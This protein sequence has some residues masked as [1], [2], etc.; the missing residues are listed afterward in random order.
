MSPTT[1]S[2]GGDSSCPSRPA[3]AG[4]QGG[5]RGRGLEQAGLRRRLG[6]GR[7]RGA[8]RVG[9]AAA[10]PLPRAPRGARKEAASTSCSVSGPSSTARA[11]RHHSGTSARDSVTLGLAVTRSLRWEPARRGRRR[12][13]GVSLGSAAPLH[14]PPRSRCL[15]FPSASSPRGPGTQPVAPGLTP[16]GVGVGKR[17]GHVRGHDL[18][19]VAVKHVQVLRALRAGDCG[20]GDG[21]RGSGGGRQ[22]PGGHEVQR[23]RRAAA[24]AGAA[25]TRD[26]AGARAERARGDR[27][28]GNGAALGGEGMGP[29]ARQGGRRARQAAVAPSACAPGPPPAAAQGAPP[30]ACPRPRCRR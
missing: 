16:P 5:D 22:P 27:G 10:K 19:G 6:R 21:A 13:P 17:E 15:I 4:R 20:R 9:A 28:V 24:G 2:P 14:A 11:R 3:R 29:R 26:D 1:W 23:G 12:R 8:W 30:L 7:G 18:E 25:R